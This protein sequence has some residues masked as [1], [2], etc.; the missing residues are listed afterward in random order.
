MEAY[1]DAFLREEKN[2]MKKKSKAQILLQFLLPIIVLSLIALMVFQ[3][4]T[5]SNMD[6]Q[7]KAAEPDRQVDIVDDTPTQP[8]E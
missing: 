8:A 2:P 7:V 3:F 5:L 6:S 4:V 1:Q